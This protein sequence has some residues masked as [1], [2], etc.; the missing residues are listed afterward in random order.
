VATP[1]LEDVHGLAAAGIPD[2]VN[3][4]VAPSQTAVG[5]VMV[6]C[7][8][9]VIVT[10]LEHPLLLVYVIVVVPGF[11]PVTTPALFT[12]ATAG[13][14]DVHG[15]TAAGVPDPVNVIVAPSQTTVGP[16]MVGCALTVI[17]TVLEHPL[18]LV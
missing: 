11:T 18:L 3:V 9:T 7:A 8:L 17:V 12:V 1:V 15:L 16:V 5:P 14:A 13:V 6:G 4:I 10:V 2:P